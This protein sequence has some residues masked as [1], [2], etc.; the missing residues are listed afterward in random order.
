M[1][2]ISSSSGVPF[3]Y[4]ASH[5][6]SA[7]VAATASVDSSY[8]PKDEMKAAI[9][10]MNQVLK[11]IRKAF[12]DCKD[13]AAKKAFR[14]SLT[15]KNNALNKRLDAA[16][17]NLSLANENLLTNFWISPEQHH[18]NDVNIAFIRA[19]TAKPESG[20]DTDANF[21]EATDVANSALAALFADLAN[22]I[23]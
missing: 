9:N 15:D 6:N 17:R 18:T 23:P 8:D 22:I 5:T 2:A 13:D 4:M 20:K 16:A 12:N 14:N 21:I 7:S 10:E 1:T 11:D 19:L 3:W